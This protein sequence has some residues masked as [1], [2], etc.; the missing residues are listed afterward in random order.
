MENVELDNGMNTAEATRTLTINDD[1]EKALMDVIQEYKDK[2]NDA[3]K[4]LAPCSAFAQDAW[5]EGTG[6]YL[7][8][9][10]WIIINNP[11]TLKEAII[12]ENGGLNHNVPTTRP[13]T[14]N[15]SSSNSS[16]QSSGS[17]SRGSGESSNSSVQSS[18][19][20]IP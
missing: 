16:N 4:L 20:Q 17:T 6:E 19:V 12:K 14:N 7:N 10:T 2:G 3:W 18:F 9:N 1:Q 8:G 11:A 15:S 13:T 5:D